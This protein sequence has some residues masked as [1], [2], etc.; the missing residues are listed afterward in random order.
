VVPAVIRKR[1]LA[2]FGLIVLS[3]MLVTAGAGLFF[4]DDISGSLTS[5]A[6]SEMQTA[7]E[8]ESENVATWVEGM[9]Q[10]ARLL[11]T[12]DEIVAGD[13]GTI[14]DLLSRE[15]DEMASGT[16][17]VS[18]VDIETG[19]VH[20]SSDDQLTSQ[21]VSDQDMEFHVRRGFNLSEVPLSEL[22]T[23]TTSTYTDTFE[24]EGQLLV[25]FLS[26]IPEDEGDI[27]ND[28][29]LLVLSRAD[30]QANSFD[31]PVEGSHTI[32]VDSTDGD[33]LLSPD[34][35]EILTEYEHEEILQQATNDSGVT[36]VGDEMVAYAPVTNSD[37]VVITHAPQS[38]VYGLLGDVQESMF[39]LLGLV[40]LGFVGVGVTLGR[41]TARA[42][43]RI[44]DGAVALSQGRLDVEQE[45]SGRID[46]VGR[47][48]AAFDDTREYL[49]TVTDQADAV[50]DQRFDDPVLDEDVPGALG[51][52]LRTME[53]NINEFIDELD[54][55]REEAERARE[56]SEVLAAELQQQVEQYSEV[57]AAAA[58]GDFSRRLDASGTDNEALADIAEAFN[59]MLEALERTVVQTQEIANEVD[60]VS[61]ELATTIEEIRE[62]SEDVSESAEEIS[63][64]TADQSDRF[65][66]V[67]D[68]MND[69]SATVE[70]IASSSAEV[71][72][73][74]Q[75]ATERSREGS[76]AAA[77]AIEE[78]SR[79]ERRT[80]EL[81][82]QMEQLEAEMTQIGDIVDLI[83]EIADQVN[84]LALNAS[85]EAARAGEAGEGFAV[86][87]DEVK[88]LAEETVE[89][90]EEVDDMVTSVQES[91]RSTADDITEMRA[92]VEEGTETVQDALDALDDI[93]ARVQEANQGVQSIDSAT[94]EQATT[95]QEV[96]TMVDEVTAQSHETETE[97]QQVAAAAQ[98]Q[99]SA[100]TEVNTATESLSDQAHQLKELLDT[101]EVS[102]DVE[103]IEEG[104]DTDGFGS[105][106]DT[107]SQ[108]GGS[109]GTD[110]ELRIDD[111]S[112]TD[113]TSPDD[114][115]DTDEE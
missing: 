47:V 91:T 104:E 52:S 57:M 60:E 49:Q 66:D 39:I 93:V 72:D 110:G 23:R 34:Q 13:S 10:N 96:V 86:V 98:E 90:T 80:E 5:N 68:R 4:I 112:P 114:A 22:N 74:S 54:Q 33:V 71:A 27:T 87:A 108:L 1:Y 42:L 15:V 76:E 20:F 109:G 2:K 44:A 81:T 94:D 26:G 46:E 48:Q 45:T 92:D 106:D 11:S 38:S 63:A 115:T 103:N 31:H 40:L 3:L 43:E 16:D 51:E 37:W 50:A 105:T 64:T 35:S 19:E 18:Y 97:V 83:D 9:R 29:A 107:D 82:E 111:D 67:L 102:E 113:D 58:D 8:S 25:G 70:E 41:N 101:F 14:G 28:G 65:A 84:M 62:T 100:I 6:Q 73:V 12:H 77:Q 55:S 32:V 89:A 78:M 85:I 95:S 30:L 99:A 75:R 53:A 36:E 79:I 69:L 17:S 88:S 56:E 59:E 21:G 61:L 7:T 24:H